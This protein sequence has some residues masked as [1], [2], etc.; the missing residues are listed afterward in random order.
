MT[1]VGDTIFIAQQMAILNSTRLPRYTISGTCS[2]LP[3]VTVKNG[4]EIPRLRFA[5]GRLFHRT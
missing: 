4:F 1:Y 3:E 5:I 2:V